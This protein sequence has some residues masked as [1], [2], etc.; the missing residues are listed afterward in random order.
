MWNY[1]CVCVQECADR[2]WWEP[3]R[4]S[5]HTGFHCLLPPETD[6][7]ETTGTNWLHECE[8]VISLALAAPNRNDKKMIVSKNTKSHR[9]HKQKKTSQRNN[10]AWPLWSF[11]WLAGLF[12]A[13]SG[14]QTTQK[15]YFKFRLVVIS[16][17]IYDL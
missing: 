5:P 12:G 1:M 16:M 6:W 2:D 17:C 7:T 9:S 13:T 10:N 4:E 15:R 8:C 14:S 11:M 3:G